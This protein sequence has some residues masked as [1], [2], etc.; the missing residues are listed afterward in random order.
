MGAWDTSAL[1][2]ELEKY[3]DCYDSDDASMNAY[4]L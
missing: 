1:V 2:L 3:H 4:A